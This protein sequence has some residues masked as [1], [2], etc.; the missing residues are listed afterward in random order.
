MRKYPV[1]FVLSI[2]SLFVLGQEKDLQYYYTKARDAYKA[3]AYS[4]FY[5]MIAEAHKIHPYHQGVL[6]QLGLAAALTGRKDEAIRELKKAILINAD[7]KLDGLSDFNSIKQSPGFLALLKLQQDLLRPVIRSDTAFV[8]KDRSLHTEGIAYD[9][10][11]DRFYLGSIHKRKV[12]KSSPK[13]EASDFC[14]EGFEGM[15]SIFGLK[16]DSKKNC[17]W[18]CS[19]PMPEVDHFDSTAR[20][21]VFK[22]DLGSG[23]LLTR[24]P[25]SA[26]G[27][28]EVFGDLIMNS[29]GDV[30]VSESKSNTVFIVNE[31]TKK[32]EPYYTSPEFWNI[33][34]ITFSEND[35]YLFIADYVKGLYRLDTK[36]RELI[37][38]TCGLDVSLKGIDGL[39]FYGNS[40]IAIQNGVSP[41]RAT[42]YFLNGAQNEITRFE[43]LDRKHPA[44]N[45]PTMGTI[46]GDTYYYIGNS[47]WGAYDDS[48]KIK[49]DEQLQDI[50]ILKSKLTR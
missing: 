7:F 34:G 27:K 26:W 4:T 16:V 3:K 14:S 20:S 47:Q 15:T 49:P 33:Q 40:L 39:N 46:I 44:F 42:Q 2:Q 17:L 41:S 25:S 5:E 35:R 38:L 12:I 21:V 31:A 36:T 11:D 22:F 45:E 10:S 50:V 30:F 8:L 37:S 24:I 13:G 48:H 32:L 23:K 1:L 19:S 29:K 6:Y 9:P 18:V 43:T 28:E